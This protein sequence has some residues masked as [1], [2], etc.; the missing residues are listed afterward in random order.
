M[1]FLS[2]NLSVY[3]S[4][5]LV[6]NRVHMP[7]P[8]AAFDTLDRNRLAHPESVKHGSKFSDKRTIVGGL[9]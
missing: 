3:S 8:V 4:E 7:V 5:P 9:Q 1:V 6:L 2:E